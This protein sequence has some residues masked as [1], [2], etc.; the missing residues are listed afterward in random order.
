MRAFRIARAL[1]VKTFAE[2]AEYR[3]EIVIWMLSGTMPIIMMFVWMELA[4][5]GPMGGYTPRDFAAYFMIVFLARQLTAVWVMGTLDRHIRMGEMSP[6]LLRPLDPYWQYLGWHVAGSLIKLPLVAPLVVL[7]LY[8]AG[9]LDAPDWANLPLFLL[10]IAGAFAIQFN[11]LYTLG[12]LAFWTD[13]ASAL[14]SVAYTL[15]MV[16]GGVLIPIDLFPA[17]LRAVLAYTPYIY[18]VDFPVK[19][20]TG[21][22]SPVEIAEGFALQAAWIAGILA[23][24]RLLW[25]RGLRRYGAVGA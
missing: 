18:V 20:L 13:Q 5:D 10:A 22:W 14:E 25:R 24:Q 2:A 3:V 8:L 21:G 23:A 16:L 7:G 15:M 1:G 11:L 4:S 19:V 12:L 17:G 6:M 9:A